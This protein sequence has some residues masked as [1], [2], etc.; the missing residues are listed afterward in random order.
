M[1][2]SL[3]YLSGQWGF[4]AVL[5]VLSVV[6]WLDFAKISSL[7]VFLVMIA[8]LQTVFL[9]R[10]LFRTFLMVQKSLGVTLW[11]EI[12][13][14]GFLGFGDLIMLESGAD[15]GISHQVCQ[16]QSCCCTL[17]IVGQDLIAPVIM[18]GWVDV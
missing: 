18:S 16:G 6:V 8:Q 17:G 15:G 7:V 5:E 9:S 14:W 11:A 4:E 13:E 2:V 3:S 10:G 1:Q 12:S